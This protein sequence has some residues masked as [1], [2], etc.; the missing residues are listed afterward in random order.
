MSV[1]QYYTMSAR[2]RELLA[3]ATKLTTKVDL[4]VE[5]SAGA[6]AFLQ[7]MPRPAIGLDLEPKA[8]A[9][10][11]EDFFDWQPPAG[12]GRIAVIGNPPFGHVGSLAS[13]FFNQAATF[14]DYIAFILPA[15]FTKPSMQ[16][17]LDRRFHL[18][19]EILLPDEPFE[20]D[21]E[22]VRYNTVFQIWER[23][24]VE[25]LQPQPVTTHPDFA[26][27]KTLE[28]ADFAVRRVGAH[29]GKIIDIP[30]DPG[31]RKGLSSSSNYYIR[32]TGS[33]VEVVRAA[34]TKCEFDELLTQA[35]S[36]PSLSKAEVIGCYDTAACLV[37]TRTLEKAY[38]QSV[39]E[40]PCVSAACAQ[41][42]AGEMLQRLGRTPMA[43]LR[44]L[45]SVETECRVEGQGRKAKLVFEANRGGRTAL[46]SV[47]VR[48]IETIG[49]FVFAD[50]TAGDRQIGTVF[51]ANLEATEVLQD[52][53]NVLSERRK[54]KTHRPMEP[55]L[56]AAFHRCN[57]PSVEKEDSE[58]PPEESP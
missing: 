14:A 44:F 48:E 33:D 46:V 29:A 11:K 38:L 39:S 24:D 43:G 16:A 19:Q 49:E 51:L 18:L 54:L 23:R 8:P 53:L 2:A 20:K 37:E 35:V 26:F 9:I 50:V 21:G 42:L 47:M 58:K 56:R 15:S 30:A 12:S 36:A 40:V 13:R 17:R 10:V 52:C 31:D 27:V 7:Y 55:V 22:K 1:D 6:G 41:S 3:E 34:F 28:E 25:R 5:P 45:A 57:G 32:A 4:F